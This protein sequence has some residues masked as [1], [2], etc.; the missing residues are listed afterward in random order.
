MSLDENRYLSP[1]ESWKRD[2]KKTTNGVRPV[3][4]TSGSPKLTE[5]SGDISSKQSSGYRTKN[6][7]GNKLFIH[8]FD[9]RKSRR[10]PYYGKD[11]AYLPGTT[12]L[13]RYEWNG[14]KLSLDPTWGPVPYLLSGQTP[15][16]APTIMGDWVILQTKWQSY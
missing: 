7:V 11:Y 1:Y 9:R 10:S 15:A 3:K 16:P 8:T 14:K 13:Y 4:E 12:S 2:R 6:T 5:A